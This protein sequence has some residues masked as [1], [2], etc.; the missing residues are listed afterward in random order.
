MI[1]MAKKEKSP[2][3]VRTCYTFQLQFC[4]PTM[5]MSFSWR[6]D[7]PPKH[8]SEVLQV[9]NGVLGTCDWIRSFFLKHWPFSFQCR[10]CSLDHRTRGHHSGIHRN[11][12]VS[13]FTC[14]MSIMSHMRGTESERQRCQSRHSRREETTVLFLLIFIIWSKIQRPKSTGFGKECSSQ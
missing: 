5:V 10:Q 1:T 9:V 3:L 6:Q 2:I 7:K 8:Q 4:T 13:V 11:A 12:S 14:P